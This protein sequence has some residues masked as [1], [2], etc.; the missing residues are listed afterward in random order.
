MLELSQRVRGRVINARA[1]GVTDF[2]DEDGVITRRQDVTEILRRNRFHQNESGRRCGFRA[3]P[4]FRRVA[5]IPVAV[6]D[7]AK[8]QGLDILNDPDDMR[9]FLNHRDNIAF[10]TTTEQV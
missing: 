9:R 2:M 8:A 5:S 10:R 3:A 4:V 1:D 7:I 6:A